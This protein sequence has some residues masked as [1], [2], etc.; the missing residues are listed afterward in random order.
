LK[1]S[2]DKQQWLLIKE[3]DDVARPADEYDIVTALPASVISGELVGGMAKPAANQA[4]KAK[5]RSKAPARASKAKAGKGA[6][7]AMPETLSPQ[8]ATLVESPPA[9]DW[10]YEIKYDGYRI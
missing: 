5:A 4:A 1:G 2:G 10:I 8:L 3:Q 6:Q 7:S 9:G